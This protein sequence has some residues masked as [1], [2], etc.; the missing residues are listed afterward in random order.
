MNRL[1]GISSSMLTLALVLV[2]VGTVSGHH[3]VTGGGW[4]FDP[5]DPD[6]DTNWQPYVVNTDAACA[7]CPN[8]LKAQQGNLGAGSGNILWIQNNHQG[9]A[10]V[11][12]HNNDNF[13]RD[14]FLQFTDADGNPTPAMPG[15][16]LVGSFRY[17]G[18]GANN[19]FV[20]TSDLEAMLQ[21]TADV[22]PIT[23]EHRGDAKHHPLTKWGVAFGQ[24][25]NALDRGIKIEQPEDYYASYI[26]LGGGT[27]QAWTNNDTPG[28]PY[29]RNELESDVLHDMDQHTL[30]YYYPQ[31]NGPYRIAFELVL[32]EDSYRSMTVTLENGNIDP[33]GPIFEL[34]EFHITDE[35]LI[36]HDPSL[37]AGDL[38][39]M[40]NPGVD[41][42]EGI[43][44][45]DTGPHQPQYWIDDIM[46]TVNGTPVAMEDFEDQVGANNN[47]T[48][49]GHTMGPYCCGDATG[50]GFFPTNEGKPGHWLPNRYDVAAMTGFVIPPLLG[51][52][53]N[54]NQITGQDVIA[55]QQNFGTVYPSDPSCDGMGLGDANDD[56]LV[57]GQ[58]VIA[59]QQN[60][61]E[62]ANPAAVPEPAAIAIAMT[63]VALRG[64]CRTTSRKQKP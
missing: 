47:D 22:G 28:E 61:G 14:G 58:D 52:A 44:W 53:N 11:D 18:V 7:A 3:D 43:V 32:G 49:S 2:P 55:V 1:I 26:N 10:T 38:V 13:G 12:R 19:G 63:L 30:S 17:N 37:A 34:G 16:T 29:H 62:V 31:S 64:T 57:T 4:E 15:D 9:D 5:V 45:T 56:C 21:D 8:I 36:G 59:V 46:I 48:L 41:K 27:F 6:P 60:Y 50:A 42:I 40:A 25:R 20:L 23:T 39:P 24:Q 35:P 51:D 54:D 33:I